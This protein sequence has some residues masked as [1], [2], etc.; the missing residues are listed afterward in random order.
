VEESSYSKRTISILRTYTKEIYTKKLATHLMSK[1]TFIFKLYTRVFKSSTFHQC[2]IIGFWSSEHFVHINK[3]PLRLNSDAFSL[4]RCNCPICRGW[5]LTT[6]LWWFGLCNSSQMTSMPPTLTQLL[7]FLGKD[8]IIQHRQEESNVQHTSALTL[9]TWITV[10]TVICRQQL[11]LN[12][13]A[14]D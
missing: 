14:A 13:S 8:D 12:L 5:A 2:L 4:R 6:A 3:I 11:P 9:K 1:F 10:N 7:L